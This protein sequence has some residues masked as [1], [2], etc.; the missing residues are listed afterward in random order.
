M[1]P[2]LQLK[3]SFNW[4]IS[5]LLLASILLTGCSL[6]DSLPGSKQLKDLIPGGE[7]DQK[8]P[9]TVGDLTVPNGMNYLKVESIGLVTGLN[10]TGSTPPS[11]MHR[12][13]LIDEMQTH[14]VEN[15]N[16]LLSSPRT[17]LV[18]LR[19][20]LPPGVRK[21]DAFDIEIRLPAHS[22]TS[23]LR[24]G[25][26]LRS[27]MRELAVLN[28]NL[29]T[30]HVAALSEGSVLVH[31]LF[32]GEAD[33]TNSR[34]GIILGGGIS[35]MDRPLGLLIK[36]KY[37]SIRTAT[38]LAAA[39]NQRFLQYTD[40]NSK[41]VA[42][43]KSDNYV[44]LVVHESYRHNVSRYMN[45]VRSIAVGESDL[46]SHER[47]ELLLAKL[48]EPTT[49][50][51]AAMQLEA[52]GTESIPTLKQGLTSDDPE[53]RFYS[54]ESLAYLDEPDAAPALS[55][56]ASQH[57][58]FRWH[59]MTALAGMDH[60]NALDAITELLNSESA[61]TRVGAFRALWTRN[62]NS[63]LVNGRK[64]SDFNFHQVETT[65]YP[66]VHIAMSKRPELIAFGN[67]IHINPVD[68][69]FAGKEII[70]KNKGDGQLQISRFS[71]DR[72]DR[73][74]TSTT[75]LSDVIRAISEVDGNYSD[76]V[77]MLQTLKKVDAIN[78]RVLVGARPRPVWN[79]NRNS[80]AG[81]N[82]QTTDFNITNPIPE[83]Y[84]DRLAETEAEAVKRNH[85]RAE[86]VNSNR[87]K[88][89]TDSNGF[90][91]KVQSAIPGL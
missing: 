3:T 25:F 56:L 79:Y 51:E 52:I 36:T 49:A 41:G 89:N 21:G 14:D 19:G 11:G 23:S 29:R 71:P 81:A 85:T 9:L 62:P 50:A 34:S 53:V 74:A 47:K 2:A 43:A 45:V 18:M 64:F 70:V 69:V 55:R 73:Y 26:L 17:S 65:A 72:A 54:A 35:H 32:R 76:I 6:T 38:R 91:D 4:N 44:E 31:S 42:N 8:P 7:D 63:P 24:Y 20:Y 13:M 60:V 15:P 80:N 10:N 22:Q 39:I 83:L 88:E 67:D 40:E 12:Q 16:A 78:A 33:N 61:E 48:L 5:C 84:F 75:K 87:S 57:I 68:H 37:S 1:K 58:A 30:G 77:D 28:Q 82:E 59:A 46:A 27:R 66:L 86:A 90:F